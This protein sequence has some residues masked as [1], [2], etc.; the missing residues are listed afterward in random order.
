LA[1]TRLI[2][3]LHDLMPEFYA[4]RFNSSMSNWLVRLVIWQERLSC[5]FAD[6]VITVSEH[7]R[8]TLI[9]RGM[10]AGKC[11]VIMNVADDRIFYR[12]ENDAPHARQDA[13]FRLI[14]HGTI[15]QR[16]GLDLAIQA[17][18]LVRAEIPH[19][20]LLIVGK[21]D[22]VESLAQMKQALKLDGQVT[23]C[24]QLRPAEELP[25]L[26]RA[27][28]AGIVPYRNDPFTDGLLPTKLMEYAALGVPAIASR[29]TAIE[30]YFANT[31]VELFEPGD[32]NALAASIRALHDCPDRLAELAQGSGKFNERYN[33]A[34]IGGQYVAL[35]RQ[36]DGSGA[37]S[38]VI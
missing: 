38:T 3:D 10:P 32:A 14:Y 17:I 29:T 16:Y 9:K 36:S 19:I 13:T 18:A 22:Y 21:G 12:S 1:G 15:V 5:G 26:I 35:V 7:W 25:A 6:H 23:I 24:D 34:N 31:M 11:S 4:A 27:A 28:D 2:L 33:W 37:F 8:Q 20:H 30:S